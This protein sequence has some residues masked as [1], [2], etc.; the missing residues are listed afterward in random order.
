MNNPQY[1][2]AATVP[3][4]NRVMRFWGEPG[5]DAG[6]LLANPPTFRRTGFD[7]STG[8][9]PRLGPDNSVEVGG[10]R[11]LLRLYQDGTLLFRVPADDDF[12]A[13][14][15]SDFQQFPR[16]NPVAVVEVHAAFIHLY[17]KVL[18]RLK[19]PPRVITTHLSLTNATIGDQRLFLTQYFSPGSTD[20]YGAKKYLLQMDPSEDEVDLS[21]EEVY[22]HPNRAAFRILAKFAGFFDMPEEEIPF[23]RAGDGREI[24]IAAIQSLR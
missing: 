22:N 20:K 12:L 6:W 1:V 24:D 11:Q 4:G 13:W 10:G 19:S 17:Q 9:V 3:D 2:L 21:P 16:L 14:A 18:E 15:E 8:D 7:T 23:C 5:Q